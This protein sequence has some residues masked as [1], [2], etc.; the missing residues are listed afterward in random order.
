MHDAVWPQ[1]YAKVDKIAEATY[2]YKKGSAGTKPAAFQKHMKNDECVDGIILYKTNG[3]RICDIRC[4]K[5]AP[6]S[7]EA[8]FL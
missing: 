2:S 8:H 7:P 6:P 4:K 1:G 5:N 3:L